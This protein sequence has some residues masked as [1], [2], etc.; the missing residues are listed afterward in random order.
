[1]PLFAINHFKFSSAN[2][3]LNTAFE[4]IPISQEFLNKKKQLNLRLTLLHRRA[5]QYLMTLLKKVTI[6]FMQTE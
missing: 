2:G 5:V 6:T 4:I 1:M 3:P